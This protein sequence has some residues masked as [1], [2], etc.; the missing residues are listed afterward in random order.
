MRYEINI[1]CLPSHLNIESI[2][3]KGILGEAAKDQDKHGEGLLLSKLRKG[4][5]GRRS[6]GWHSI[7]SD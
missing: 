4:K 6:E 1:E 3:M 5:N 2:E 7:R